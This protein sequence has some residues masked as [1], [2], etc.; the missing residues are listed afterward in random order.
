MLFMKEGPY[1]KIILSGGGSGGPVTPLLAISQRLISDDPRVEFVF[2]G[3]KHGPEKVMVETFRVGNQ[4]I[5]FLSLPS[6]K[7]RRYF[8]LLNFFDFF[9][10]LSALLISFFI[11]RK[12]KPDLVISAGGF[13]SVPLVWVAYLKKI[14]ILIHQQDVRPGLANKL[15][16]PFANWITVS[17]EK[18]LRDYGPRAIWIGNP[19]N[20]LRNNDLSLINIKKK[21]SILDDKPLILVTGGGTG[22]SAINKLIKESAPEIN[23]WAQ[24]ISLTGKGKFDPTHVQSN[25][26]QAFELI[27]SDESFQLMNIA[28]L[29]ISRC[30]LATLTELSELAKPAILIPMPDSHQEDNAAIFKQLKAAIV[31][32]QKTITPDI[33]KISIKRILEDK[34]LRTNLSNNISKVMKPGATEAMSGL[35]WEILAIKK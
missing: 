7:L 19:V 32:S 34:E 27:P 22:S 9:K 17:F 21:Y 1:K 24:I 14:P 11:L 4:K 13:P 3:T 28:D 35:I 15:M 2:V 25:L 18:S 6:G 10:I 26:Y 31:L 23:N 12:E 20:K 29:V 16:A 33:L 8:S 30:G 5:K